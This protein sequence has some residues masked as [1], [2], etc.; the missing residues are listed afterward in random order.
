VNSCSC[1]T[2]APRIAASLSLHPC[3]T[4]HLTAKR[5]EN[6]ENF[7]KPLALAGILG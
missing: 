4:F 2:S 6:S 3:C 5:K 1:I 7:N